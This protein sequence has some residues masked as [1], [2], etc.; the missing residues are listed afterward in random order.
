M[1]N[2]TYPPVVLK[3][4]TTIKSSRQPLRVIQELNILPE[5]AHYE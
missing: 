3:I 2:C 1:Y 4:V 5:R